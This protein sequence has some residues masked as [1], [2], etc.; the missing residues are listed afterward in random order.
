MFILCL[1]FDCLNCLQSGCLC[2]NAFAMAT[3]GLSG[4]VTQEFQFY[5]LVINDGRRGLLIMNML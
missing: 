5:F 3:P 4:I 1:K 2:N